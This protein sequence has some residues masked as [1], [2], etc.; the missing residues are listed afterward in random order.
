MYTRDFTTAFFRERN[1][2][3]DALKDFRKKWQKTTTE[4]K[5]EFIDKMAEEMNKAEK[6]I[7]SFFRSRGFDTDQRRKEWP[8]MTK[9]EKEEFIKKREEFMNKRMFNRDVF[10]NNNSFGHENFFDNSN[11]RE[12][13]E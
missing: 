12:K 11:S 8:A 10:F 13:K 7:N 3:F 9:D 6:N 5:I 2:S 1:Y 4:E